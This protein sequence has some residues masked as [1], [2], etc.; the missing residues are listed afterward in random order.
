M[1]KIIILIVLLLLTGCNNYNDIKYLAVI[2]EIGIDYDKNYIVYIKVLSNNQKEQDKVYKEICKS[3]NECFDNI[4]NKLSK[5]L[6]LT[7]LDL[8]V[9][10]KNL[11]KENYDEI[12]SLFMKNEQSRNNFITIGVDNIN[13]SFFKIDS[14]DIINMLNL[15]INSN[16]IVKPV[17]F[18]NVIKDI[19]NYN[20][21]YI[22]FIDNEIIGYIEIY[23]N[24]K[25]LTKEESISI[26]FIKS[27][28]KSI[29]ITTDKSYKLEDCNTTLIP[30]ND[31]INI[32]VSCN[33]KGTKEEKDSLKEYIERIINEF[34]SNN[35]Q[36][37]LVYIKEKYNIKNELKVNVK[38]DLSLIKIDT[39]DYFE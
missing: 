9:L 31:I 33:Y 20:L 7:H 13:E 6:Y 14:K 1:K 36:N 29:T 38:V 37:Y 26:N 12:I 3:L 34:I 28:I 5:K 4:N 8:L 16:G 19:L 32:K 24:I 35:D 25:L 21:S 22:P 2:N 15:S 39:G 23:E 30:K 17:N 27:N 18:E 11:K 10:T